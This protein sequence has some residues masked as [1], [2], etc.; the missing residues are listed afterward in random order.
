MSSA[1]A[2]A[3]EQP[4]LG[5]READPQRAEDAAHAVDAD[6]TDR[7]VDLDGSMAWTDTATRTPASR[8]TRIAISC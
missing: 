5:R 3:V 6:R 2:A 7:V 8:P 1:S 4:A